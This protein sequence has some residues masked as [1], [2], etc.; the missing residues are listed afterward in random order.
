MS[1]GVDCF[2]CK[3]FW[4]DY[5]PDVPMI[6]QSGCGKGHENTISKPVAFEKM[7]KLAETHRLMRFLLAVIIIIVISPVHIMDIIFMVSLV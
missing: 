1:E 2:K 3:H 4:Y 6:R 5:Y 7:K